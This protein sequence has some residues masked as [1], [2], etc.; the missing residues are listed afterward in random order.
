MRTSRLALAAFEPNIDFIGVSTYPSFAY[1][2][3][4]AMPANYYT[5]L[6][7]TGRPDRVPEAGFS[8]ATGQEDINSGTEEQQAAF[9]ERLLGEAEEMDAPFAV[10]FAI[11]DPSYARDSTFAA[12][13]HIGLLRPTRR[14]GVEALTEVAQRPFEEAPE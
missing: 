11:W 4:A 7:F 9:V 6:R 3:V 5:R 13:Q 12:F 2:D 1:A 14:E 10:W 8:S